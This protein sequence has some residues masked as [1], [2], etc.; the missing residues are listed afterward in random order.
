MF[1][2]LLSLC[3]YFNFRFSVTEFLFVTEFPF[4]L[5]PAVDESD[6][7]F[8]AVRNMTKRLE[9]ELRSAKR[10]HLYCGEVLL[11][12]GLLQRIAR[13]IV[14]MAESEPCG[15]RGCMLYIHFEGDGLYKQLSS[16]KCDPGTA[17]TFELYLTFKQAAN[18]WN[19]FLPQ[20][21][22]WVF[23]DTDSDTDMFDRLLS[24]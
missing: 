15:L 14:S 11:P 13:D 6:S 7:T 1:L 4:E 8:I 2:I 21:L 3:I 10:T 9:R 18:S 16:I 23:L 22:K 20:F 24:F 17:T 19:S 12:C 5:S